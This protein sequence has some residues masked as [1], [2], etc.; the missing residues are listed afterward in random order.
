M[1]A[2]E[3]ELETLFAKST[4]LYA[5]GHWKEAKEIAT[6]AQLRARREVL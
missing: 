5:A 6:G 4:E 3:V 2:V 1:S